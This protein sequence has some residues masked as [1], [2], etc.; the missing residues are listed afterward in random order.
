[1]HKHNEQRMI[2]LQHFSKIYFLTSAITNHYVR[3]S[4]IQGS[5]NLRVMHFNMIFT[6]FLGAAAGSLSL[7]GSSWREGEVYCANL[8]HK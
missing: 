5:C 1:M 4:Y 8:Q 7:G 6:E 3:I 2:F